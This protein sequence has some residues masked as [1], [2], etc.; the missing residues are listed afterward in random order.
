MVRCHRDM[1]PFPVLGT[2]EETCREHAVMLPPI[3]PRGSLQPSL[4]LLCRECQGFIVP[5]HL[6]TH[7]RNHLGNGRKKIVE[8]SSE[9]PGP[10]E[11]GQSQWPHPARLQRYTAPYGPA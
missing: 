3:R 10:R 2:P 5:D 6:P 8:Q 4:V 7:L 9:T 11:T 1:P